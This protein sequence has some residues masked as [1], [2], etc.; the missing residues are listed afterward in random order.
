MWSLPAFDSCLSPLASCHMA[1]CHLMAPGVPQRVT[2][3]ST[4]SG[5]RTVLIWKAS[6]AETDAG[7]EQSRAPPAMGVRGHVCISGHPC[8]HRS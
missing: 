2:P 7:L 5:Q 1:P 4:A 6:P 8:P 3:C